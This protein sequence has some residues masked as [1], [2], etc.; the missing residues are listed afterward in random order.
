MVSLHSSNTAIV[1]IDP[2]DSSRSFSFSVLGT[3]ITTTE[4]WTAPGGGVLEFTG[5]EEGVNYTLERMITN[6]SEYHWTEL[7][8]EL[9]PPDTN[10]NASDDPFPEYRPE[11]YLNSSNIDGLSFAQNSEVPRGSDMF[12][13]WT[14]D[15][16]ANRDLLN[17]SDPLEENIGSTFMVVYGL[18]DFQTAVNDGFLVYGLDPTHLPEPGPLAL[19]G[20][21]LAGLAF[22]RRSF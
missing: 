13:T 16:F 19:L 22:V 11:G 1:D 3:T 10:P 14:A 8:F 20:L 6:D 5:L 4:T 12:D 7:E 2:D 18:R 15:E 9:F 21:M 17:F